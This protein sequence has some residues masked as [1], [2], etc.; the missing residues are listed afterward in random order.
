VKLFLIILLIIVLAAYAGIFYL[1]QTIIPTKIRSAIVT[2]LEDVTQKKVLL[3]SVRFNI[4]KG[5]I[6]KDLIIRDDLN[7]VINVKEAHCRFLL[8]PL[9]DKRIVISRLILESPDVFVE[10]RPD[11]SINLF[12]LFPK[13][14]LSGKDFKTFI[15]RI[16][17]RNGT[18]NFHDLTFEPMYVNEIKNLD[19]DI[20]L[21]LPAKIKYD[22]KFEIPSDLPV[23]IASSGEYSVTAKEFTA[24]IRTRDFSP[25]EVAEYYEKTGLSF[26]EGTFDSVINLKYKDGIISV[27]TESET[28]GLELSKDDIYL[29]VNGN[30]RTHARYDF[31][32]KKLDYTGNVNVRD[33]FINGIK[34]IES[35]DAIKGRFEYSNLGISSDNITATVLGLPVVAKVSANGLDNPVIDIDASS[36]IKLGPFQDMLK[37]K[38]ELDVPADFNGDAKLRLTMQYTVNAPEAF[39]I[40]GLL[41]F[42]NASVKVNRG[43]DVLD[44]VTGQFQIVPNQVSWDDVGFRYHDVHYTSS[45]ALTNFKTPGIQL[46]LASRDISV[47]TVFALNGK[48]FNF[49]KFH[50]KYLTSGI[51]ASGLLDASNPE[52]LNA[53]IRGSIN[54]NT[55]DLKKPLEK[56]KEKFNRINP[57]G[58][59]RSEFSLKGDLKNLKAC[60]IDAN[61]SS[62]DLLLYGLRLT[63]STMNYSQKN[64]TGDILFMRSFLYGG[65]MG[66]TGK[67]N[68]ISKDIPYHL[69]ADVDGVKIEKFKLDTAFKDKDIAGSV[70]MSAKLNGFLNDVSKLSGEGKITVTEGKIWQLNLF[71]GMGT[72]L[73]TSD[74]SNII[75]KECSSEFTIRDKF[76]YTDDLNLKSDLLD[77]NGPMKIG[78]DN[79]I[80][81][82]V[83]A[84]FSEDVITSGKKSNMRVA[85]GRY[86]LIDVTGTLKDSQ[87]KVKPDVENI[88]EGIAEHFLSE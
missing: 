28:K 45:G 60:A 14:G 64:G 42:L 68:W 65:S 41:Y 37:K 74:F 8:I 19:A 44:N 77:I 85:F 79:T 16:S 13:G 52:R 57:K 38:F 7:A 36:D 73:F 72:L 71:R 22:L 5:L 80:K 12:A 87:Y 3:G 49:S 86:T 46:K 76:I 31:A 70:R 18:V 59:I 35:I 43:K 1:N 63:N 61:L 11:N 50:G 81:A 83:K 34:Y 82:T 39:Q 75:F 32:A 10:R 54:V 15:H 27:D 47:D 51:L 67:V 48:V 2:G 40:K 84:E 23:K 69:E 21:S 30:E 58:F 4:F 17:V 26:S 6:L 24:E 29:K 53:D 66:A 9:F 88:V 25:E 20:H 33:M 78:F 55:E 62:E 56:F